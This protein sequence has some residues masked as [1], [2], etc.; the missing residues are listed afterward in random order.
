MY[1]KYA[2]F[3]DSWRPVT[4]TFDLFNWKLAL[5]L[6]IPLERLYQFWFFSTFFFV[7]DIRA[8]TEQMDRQTDGQRRRVN[9]K[10]KIRRHLKRFV[11]HA[12]NI[13]KANIII[14]QGS[15]A[16]RLRCGGIFNNRFIANV[17]LILSER[18]LKIGKYLM[19]DII[20]RRWL[21]FLG[22]P[23]HVD[24]STRHCIALSPIFNRWSI[25]QL[26]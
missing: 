22:N 15:V 6:P 21:T 17:S 10:V 25:I 3:L 19:K 14:S 1:A 5:Y 16:M 20:R 2:A 11:Y 18:I 9:N 12:V 23:I 26:V 8:R 7:F 4:L 13:S 24:H